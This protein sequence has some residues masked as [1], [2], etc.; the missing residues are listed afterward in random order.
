MGRAR[1]DS[2]QTMS[3]MH[4]ANAAQAEIYYGIMTVLMGATTSTTMATPMKTTTTRVCCREDNIFYFV[5]F[6]VCMLGYVYWNATLTLFTVL[7][8]NLKTR[9]SPATLRNCALYIMLRS[10]DLA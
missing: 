2:G 6:S 5:F 1:S 9:K 4:V 7:K 10:A 8:S 3:R